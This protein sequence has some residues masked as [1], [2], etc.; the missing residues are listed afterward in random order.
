MPPLGSR[1]HQPA[2]WDQ[3]RSHAIGRLEADLRE[4]HFDQTIP[5]L[6][7]AIPLARQD[8]RTAIERVASWFTLSSN[9]EY[10]DFDLEIA[11]R[12]ALSSVK[13]YYSNISIHSS[14]GA[15]PNP[16]YFKGSVCR[17]SLD[18]SS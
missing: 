1:N 3:I 5:G 2:T 17:F 16:S 11:Y 6:L 18:S 9:S 15:I 14:Y 13:T 7:S 12:A 4:A 10:Q 8:L